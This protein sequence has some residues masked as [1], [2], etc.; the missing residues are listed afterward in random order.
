MEFGIGRFLRVGDDGKGEIF[1]GNFGLE[2]EG[3]FLFFR[4]L[5]YFNERNDRG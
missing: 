1:W 4:I 5:L 3:R 2:K